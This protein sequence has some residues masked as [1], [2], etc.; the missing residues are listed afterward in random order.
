MGPNGR[1]SIFFSLNLV[2]DARQNSSRILLR[3]STLSFSFSNTIVSSAKRLAIVHC[4]EIEV[5]DFIRLISLSDLLA[6]PNDHV[7][8]LLTCLYLLI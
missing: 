1:K 3:S 4:Y 7:V 6:F 8:F 5:Q 2:D